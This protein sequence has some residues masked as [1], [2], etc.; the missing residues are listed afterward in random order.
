MGSWITKKKATCTSTGTEVRSCTRSG[1]TYS[2]E[3]TIKKLGHTASGTTYVITK[4]ATCTTDG[5]EVLKCN[6]AGCNAIIGERTIKKLDHSMGSWI[7]KKKATCTSTGTEVRSCTRSGCT[8]SEERTIK[9]L[10]HTASGTTYVITKPATCTTDG[11]EV[12]KC[13][14]AGCNKI[15]GQRIIKAKGHNYKLDKKDYSV[16]CSKC[17]TLYMGKDVTWERYINKISST[18]S[19]LKESEKEDVL[20]NFLVNKGCNVD[21][22]NNA[23][24][25]GKNGEFLKAE[26][27]GTLKTCMTSL[28]KISKL[29]NFAYA[30][31]LSQFIGY[32]SLGADANVLLTSADPS[33]N[34]VENTIDSFIDFASAVSGCIPIAGATYSQVISSLKKPL[35]V[36]IKNIKGEIGENTLI[37]IGGTITNK[38]THY[39][40]LA[41][42]NLY[43]ECAREI[44]NHYQNMGYPIDY[45]TAISYLDYY[46]YGEMN[47]EIKSVT[48]KSIE[49]IY[50]MI[51]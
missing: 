22:I 26:A 8:Y 29:S 5:K 35:K 28:D 17:Y 40:D 42:P 37:I 30:D 16:R 2:E 1:C 13:N 4:P 49:E 33:F 44:Y 31:E 9:K 24:E 15:V 12:L 27:V 48:G 3:R 25:C 46:I 43:Y 50:E 47:N 34:N 20:K 21:I 23:F 38:C 51:D 41:D 39:S 19:S 32:A 36:A 11:K 7:T 18:Y 45:S 14:R 6:R 10:G